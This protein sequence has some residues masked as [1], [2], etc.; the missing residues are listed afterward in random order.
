M[1][2]DNWTYGAGWLHVG[3]RPKFLVVTVLQT[4]ENLLASPECRVLT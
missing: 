2:K 3:P 1:K 4:G